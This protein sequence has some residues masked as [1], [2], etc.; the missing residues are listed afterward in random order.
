MIKEF[1]K[2]RIK[3]I[4][5]NIIKTTFEKPS[6]NIILYLGKLKAFPIKSGTKQDAYSCDH[7]PTQK[8][9][10]FPKQEGKRKKRYLNRECGCDTVVVWG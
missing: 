2:L 4:F 1:T 7:Y 5:L 10:S 8:W 9:K 3:G 6:A